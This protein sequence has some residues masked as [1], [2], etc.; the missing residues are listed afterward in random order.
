M[1][2]APLV[3]TDSTNTQAYPVDFET[4]HAQGR[5]HRAVHLEISNS[6]AE[7]FVWERQDGRL[8]IPGGHVDW[9]TQ[10]HRPESYEEAALRETIEELN[11]LVNWQVSATEARARLHGHLRRIGPLV[12]N[13]LPSP[14]GHNNEWVAVFGLAWEG[15]WGDPC[16]FVLSEEG[17]TAPRWLSLEGIKQES[18]Q[19]P[20]NAALRLFLQ[21]HGILI[22][23]GPQR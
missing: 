3:G 20:I 19:H 1:A 17:H 18:M 16:Q 2:Y 21:R 8:E 7:F 4:A 11:L 15:S 6:R 13:Q 23:L 22:P 14:Q 9:I 5:P 12:I 10:A